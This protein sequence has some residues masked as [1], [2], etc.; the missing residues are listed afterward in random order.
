M[1]RGMDAN[2]KNVWLLGSSSFLNDV[3]GRMIEPILPF[4]ITSLGGGGVAVGLA[5]GLREGL[6]NIFK[7]F[8]GWASDR[9][10]KRK[11][12]ILSGYILSS[13][14]KFFILIANS[15]QS[16]T[17]FL[18]LE[19]FGKFRDAPRDAVVSYSK[20]ITGKN[21]GIVDMLDTLGGIVGTLIVLFLFWKFSFSFK[22]IILVAAA[23]AVLSPLPVLFAKEPKIKAIKKGFG[24]SIKDL[25]GRL[26][27]FVFVCSVFAF[28]NFG[29]YFFLILIAKNLTNSTIIALLF[30]VLYNIS[31]AIFAVPFGKLSDRVE[32]KKILIAGFALLFAVLL[33][34]AFFS[35]ILVL[36]FLFI[37]YGLV[38]AI[39]HPVQRAIVSDLS[40]KMKGTAFGFFYT[41]TGL[42]GIAGGI[43]AGLFWNVN[44]RLMFEYLSVV[45]FISI[46]LL[47]FAKER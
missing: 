39:T 34:F 41:V 38:Y 40:G 15:W 19:R 35:S 5:S 23:I 24:N 7:I 31:Y 28:G 2:L 47:M 21:L 14:F 26:K 43:I 33:G 37:L 29:L 17:V 16:L 32:R 45:S 30:F 4:L 1:K 22:K 18:S 10:G 11:A 13:I 6:A 42:A 9:F 36:A 27:Y 44:P 25:N 12:F 20:K 3:G 46:I 8:G